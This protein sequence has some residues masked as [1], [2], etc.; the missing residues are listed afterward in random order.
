M[1]G[2]FPEGKWIAICCLR[3]NKCD[4]T[5]NS[6]HRYINTLLL[7]LF[8]VEFDTVHFYISEKQLTEQVAHMQSTL[9]VQ[10][11]KGKSRCF[12]ERGSIELKMNKWSYYFLL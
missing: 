7:K 1:L 8:L 10:T 11:Q 3:R 6:Q 9:E 4:Q 5:A 12:T 2:I